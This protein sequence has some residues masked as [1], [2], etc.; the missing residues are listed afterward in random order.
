MLSW[1]RAKTQTQWSF[2]LIYG[3]VGRGGICALLM[4]LLELTRA[5]DFSLLRILL[6]WIFLPAGGVVFG[7]MMCRWL[8]RRLR[9]QEAI[10]P[11]PGKDS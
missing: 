5:Q 11:G 4:M 3:V 7:L 1:L 2:V 6:A 9:H 8:Q 10:S